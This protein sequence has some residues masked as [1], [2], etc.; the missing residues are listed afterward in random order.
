MKRR[1][2]LKG[3][4]LSAAP[5]LFLQ[6]TPKETIEKPN[7]IFIMA[8]DLGYADLGCYGQKK[9]KTPNIDK[10]AANGMRFT[11]CYAGAT[12]CAPSRS[13]LMTGQHTGHTR[14]R[15]NMCKYGGTVGHKGNRE[16]RRMNLL[17]EDVTVA[18]VMQTAGYRTCLAGK[19]HIGGFNPDAGPLDRGFDEFYGALTYSGRE[20]GPAYWPRKWFHNREMVEVTG[21]QNGEKGYYRT[22]LNTDRSISFIKKNLNRPFFLYLAYSNPHSP[23][24]APNT[25]AYDH[26][27]WPEEEKLYASM[28]DNLDRNVGKLVQALKDSG[29]EKK[30]LVLFCS[31]NGPRSEP[32]EVQTRVSDFFDSNGPLQGYKRD[33]YEGGIRVPMI[34]YWPDKVPKDTVSDAI[35]YFADVLPTA[36]DLAG[37]TAPDNIDG[38]SMVPSLMDPKTLPKER[39]LYWEFFEGGF[40]QA[41]RWNQWK[42]IRPA[43]GKPLMLFNLDNDLGEEKN[44]ADQHPEIIEQFETYLKTAR[45]ESENWP[46]EDA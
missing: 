44:I 46:L 14:I 15:G 12:I 5:P 21:N 45:S 34:A 30:T 32:S 16:V 10:L 2:F 31:D 19:W 11:Q 13:V 23:F 6:C 33:L 8:D 38:V 7:I 20:H 3:L 9:I 35:W 39:Y 43:L 1:T 24:D 41:A 25:K 40:Q 18:S 4:S 27:D 36:A 37:A 26:E 28:V 42:A 17:K 29:L 22:D